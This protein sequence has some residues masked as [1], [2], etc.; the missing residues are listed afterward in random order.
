M[1][2]MISRSLILLSLAIFSANAVPCDFCPDGDIQAPDDTFCTALLRLARDGNLYEQQEE[3]DFN[4][5]IL[6]NR[7]GCKITS[8]HTPCDPCGGSFDVDSHV[9]KTITEPEGKVGL[10]ESQYSCIE[11]LYSARNGGLDS[12][13]C[14]ALVI[15]DSGSVCGRC[16]ETT[17][18]D[19]DQALCRPSQILTA[20]NPQN[21]P[22]ASTLWSTALTCDD[23]IKG[24]REG[25]LLS[26]RGC[27]EFK[28]NIGA[29]FFSPRINGADY[30]DLSPCGLQC[31]YDGSTLVIQGR[32]EA[33]SDMPSDGPSLAPT[34]MP[35]EVESEVAKNLSIAPPKKIKRNAEGNCLQCDFKDDSAF[36]LYKDFGLAGVTFFE[37]LSAPANEAECKEPNGQCDVKEA[38][39]PDLDNC[40]LAGVTTFDDLIGIQAVIP[41]EKSAYVALYK[42]TIAQFEVAERCS[43]SVP[44]FTNCEEETYYDM[45][46]GRGIFQSRADEMPSPDA[47]CPDLEKGWFNYG[48]AVEI[49]S[50][51]W[52][53]GKVSYC[54]SGPI[55][56]A[57][58][59]W[60]VEPNG[61]NYGDM[62][63]VNAGWKLPGAVY[64]CCKPLQTCS[65][66]TSFD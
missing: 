64:K 33:G 38:L 50:S 49:P 61:S 43:R 34:E 45:A 66:S 11:M 1:N 37:A 15:P 24:A 12:E 52:K 8:P 21:Y 18:C 30:I 29:A 46:K 17:T 20:S 10:H 60:P 28:D 55:Q 9:L 31:D 51:I 4:I 62:R 14:E 65:V 19:I 42:D 25:T 27:D 6:A 41:P 58:A 7:C 32:V 2:T 63:D 23:L 36:Y 59:V 53:N 44:D 5:P 22:G 40:Y 35:I 56:N 54:F 26:S 47:L 13:N 48:S 57:A 16:V 39:Y 3:C